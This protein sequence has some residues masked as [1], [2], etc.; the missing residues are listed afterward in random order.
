MQGVLGDSLECLLDVDGFL[1]GSL[2][3]GNVTL[4][5]APGHRA[6]LGDLSL[7]LLHVYLVT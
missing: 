4:G 7:V 5:L 2:K 3:V 1:R 6:F